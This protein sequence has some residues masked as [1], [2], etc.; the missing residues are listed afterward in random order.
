MLAQEPDRQLAI[1]ADDEREPEAVILVVAIP[2]RGTCELRIPKSQYDGIAVLE[3]IKRLT[4][5]NKVYKSI[6][7]P[8]YL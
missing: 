8:R 1:T 5:S 6:T 7:H 3:L 2:E 4:G